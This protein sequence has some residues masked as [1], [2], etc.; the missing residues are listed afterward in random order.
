MDKKPNAP[1][2]DGHALK[3]GRRHFLKSAA[4]GAAALAVTPA[5]QAQQPSAF[6]AAYTA[7]S[8]QQIQRDTALLAPPAATRNVFRPG[9]DLMV[10]VLKDM[11]IEFVAANNGSSFEGLQESV[12]NYGAPPNHNP[13]Y[14][15]ALHEES[16]VDMANGYGKAEGK[17]MAV[18]LH[19][20][21]GI[22]HASMAIYQAFYSG[23]PMILIVGRDD[24]FIQAHTANDMAAMC[25]SFTKWD[26]Q[27]KTLPQ[28]LDALQEAYRQAV[29]PPTGPTLV[30]IDMELQKEEARDL[31]V[32]PFRPAVIAGCDVATAR[33]IAQKL[34]AADNPRLATGAFRTPEGCRAAVALAELIG[35][36]ASTSA[37]QG[38]MGFPQRHPLCGPGADTNYDYILGLEANSP[39]LSLQRPTTAALTATRDTM[40]IGFGGLRNNPPAAGRGAPRQAPGT[41]LAIDAQASLPLII[42]EVTRLMTPAQRER[43]AERQQRHAQA[44]QAA[45]LSALHEAI[46]DK[47]KG[48][49][50]SPVSTARLYAELWPLIANEDWCLASPSSFSS[51]HHMQLWDHNKPYSYLGGQGAGGMGYGLGACTGA[52]LAARG[53]KRFVIN[54]QTDGDFNYTPGSLWS[55]VH[56]Q[57]PMLT[58]MHNNRAWHQEF[59]FI[60]YMAGVRGRGTDRSHIGTTL[61]DPFI[62]YAKLAQGYGMKAEGP[63]DNPAQLSAALER[64]VSAVKNGE[65]YLIDVLTQPR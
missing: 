48:W 44:N 13:E 36:S 24:E 52:A 15:T 49:D 4:G 26:A 56:H 3:A 51:S 65:P 47:R 58:V 17:P 30:V 43:S 42:G 7:P 35:A 18:M 5:S 31:V 6:A 8:Y 10:Q 55:A 21:I 25:R 34:L 53:R 46:D 63:I 32:P 14:I 61:R 41:V 28:C 64:G 37:Q 23:T 60:Q 12:I 38:P 1:G 33:D 29:T 59:M 22:Q 45:R 62:D 19:G 9:S 39:Q 27:P 20:T 16:S 40:G 57:L 54:I 2:V 50:L 11:G